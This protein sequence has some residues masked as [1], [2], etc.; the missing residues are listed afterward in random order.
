MI[1][2]LCSLSWLKS[3]LIAGLGLIFFF[4]CW[5][6]IC[7]KIYLIFHFL[8]SYVIVIWIPVSSIIPQGLW[9]AGHQIS[10]LRCSRWHTETFQTSAFSDSRKPGFNIRN[11]AG[12]NPRK[13]QK[14]NGGVTQRKAE[15]QRGCI[16]KRFTILNTWNSILLGHLGR[17]RRKQGHNLAE[18]S[19]Q[20]G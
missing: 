3:H 8:L 18:H 14:A 1:L 7:L 19:D 2:T 13:S 17:Q 16:T 9:K 15:P 20:Y 11:L 12:S 10:W 6:G 4:K 5:A